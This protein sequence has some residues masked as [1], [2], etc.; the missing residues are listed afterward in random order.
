MRA[1][2]R[3]LLLAATTAPNMINLVRNS[4]FI[5]NCSYV[6]QDRYSDAEDF[7]KPSM[8]IGP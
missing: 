2:P 5:F 6:F 4:D 1:R 8:D 7:F 3:A